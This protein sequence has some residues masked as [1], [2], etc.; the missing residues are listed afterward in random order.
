M[1]DRI[2]SLIGG[3]ENCIENAKLRGDAYDV[4]YMSAMVTEA[5]A[6]LADGG[7]GE[8]VRAHAIYRTRLEENEGEE[9]FFAANWHNDYIAQDGERI[10]SGLFVP[11][12]APTPECAPREA[13]GQWV[14]CSPALLNAGVSCAHT[15]RRA[16]EC[17]PANGGHDH[18]IAHTAPQA[19]DAPR[20]YDPATQ[21]GDPNFDGA[22]AYEAHLNA[23]CA[24]REAQPVAC[25]CK[26]VLGH[27]RSCALF[28]E[29]MML[30]K[31][32]APT[33]ERADADTAGASD[34]GNWLW[35][36]LMDYCK[37][38]GIAPATHNRLF[39]IVKRARAKFA[40]PASHERA[41]AGKDAGLTDEERDQA[42]A[43]W[44]AANTPIREAMAFI[45]G[46]DAARAI[47]AANKEPK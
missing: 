43:R 6:L 36:E 38:R 8:A 42:A 31:D 40:T 28:D 10:V 32:A 4:G 9:F 21:W 22:E 23:E 30:P 34:V 16:C 12:T 2:E 35:S 17:S 20:K 39:E 37:E 5:R 25:T 13:V 27:S 24:P 14:H 41:D 29:S 47:L 11:D 19:E 46:F 18:F 44:A 3:L 33:P 26:G 1:K 15:P 7:K 45:D